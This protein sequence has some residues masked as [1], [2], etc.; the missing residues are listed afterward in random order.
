MVVEE[1]DGLREAATVLERKEM[2]VE[3]QQLS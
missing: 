3:R 1:R 2:V